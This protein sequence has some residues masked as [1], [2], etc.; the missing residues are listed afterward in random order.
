MLTLISSEFLKKKVFLSPNLRESRLT[1]E[2]E[3]C[4]QNFDSEIFE[5]AD[6]STNS[7]AK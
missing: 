7:V 3:G 1:L 4:Q 6:F 2:N 5:E